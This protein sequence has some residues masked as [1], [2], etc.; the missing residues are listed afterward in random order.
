MTMLLLWKWKIWREGC[1][2]YRKRQRNLM[3]RRPQQW[4][5]GMECFWKTRKLGKDWTWSQ[6]WR[7]RLLIVK[8]DKRR[9]Q[10]MLRK[11]R[12]W[13][14]EDMEKKDQE[15]TQEVK[16]DMQVHLEKML[17]TQDGST[18]LTYT[19][20]TYKISFT[21]TKKKPRNEKILTIEA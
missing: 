10:D 5:L 13:T 9:K 20:F 8:T 17:K 21:H 7:S 4:K 1:Q 18:V 6:E 12:Q 14:N 3:S 15:K 11:E 2:I 19:Q 16:R